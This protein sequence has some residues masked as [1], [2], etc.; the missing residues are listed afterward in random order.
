MYFIDI[1]DLLL[2][3][4]PEVVLAI[5]FGVFIVTGKVKHD[6]SIIKIS[7]S[8][9]L[10]LVTFF[11]IRKY[12]NSIGIIVMFNTILYAC[13]FKLNFYLN[14]RKSIM[15]ALLVLLFILFTEIITFPFLDYIT[16]SVYFDARVQATIITRLIQIILIIILVKF[17]IWIGNINLLNDDWNKLNKEH[18]ILA[19]MVIAMIALCMVFISNYQDLFFKLNVHMRD[20]KLDTSLNMYLYVAQNVAFA[21]L[22]FYLLHR[23]NRF[24]IYEEYLSRHDREIFVDLLESADA[25]EIKRYIEIAELYHSEALKEEMKGGEYDEIS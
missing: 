21:S 16:D 24:V 7:I 5:I 12:A 9:I 11:F 23:I 13:V 14:L 8:V 17:N 22:V 6:K 19:T 20:Y 15:A 2:V 10:L 3:G 4:V 1:L 18:R 25:D